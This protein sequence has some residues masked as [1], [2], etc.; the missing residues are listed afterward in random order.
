[1]QIYLDV[2]PTKFHRTNVRHKH[3]GYT[4]ELHASINEENSQDYQQIF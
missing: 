2:S 4:I 1:M 3:I